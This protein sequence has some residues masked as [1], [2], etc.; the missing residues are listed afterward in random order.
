P[1]STFPTATAAGS[2][3]A[4]TML[5]LLVSSR[6]SSMSFLPGRAG[7]RTTFA[8][9]GGSA[10]SPQTNVVPHTWPSSDT[11]APA[12]HAHYPRSPQDMS[13]RYQR[14]EEPTSELP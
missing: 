14:P 11:L 10:R 8:A 1:L 4:P 6:T 9:P 12:V 7:T 3:L 2:A 13:P 5:T